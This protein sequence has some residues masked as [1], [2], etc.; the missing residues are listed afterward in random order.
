MFS[1]GPSDYAIPVPLKDSEIQGLLDIHNQYRGNVSAAY[2]FK[3]Y[4]DTELAKLAQAHSNM[5]AFDH[6]LAV[7]RL[8]PKFGWKNGQN[9]IMA[10]EIRSTPASLFD[11]MFS[12]EKAHFQYGLGCDKPGTCLHY[13]Q[14][15]L[16]NMTRMGCGQTHCLYPDRIQRM[17]TCNY[18][19]SQYTDNYATPYVISKD[20]FGT[21][22]FTIIFIVSV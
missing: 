18:I 12:S 15:M 7:N 1:Y 8:T 5:C 22:D 9:M 11:L 13:T 17:V 20:F 19:H 21:Y 3:L 2:M 6:D 16:S 4:Y 10:T 14:L